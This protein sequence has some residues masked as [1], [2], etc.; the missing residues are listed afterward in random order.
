MLLL[1]LQKQ[2]KLACFREAQQG[3]D[4][5]GGVAVPA[6]T[7]GLHFVRSLWLTPQMPPTSSFGFA[8]A[9]MAAAATTTRAT[10]TSFEY[11]ILDGDGV[12]L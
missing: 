11:S 1:K 4:G 9:D 7:A 12:C 6:A 10:I 8:V 3:A 5:R 2:V